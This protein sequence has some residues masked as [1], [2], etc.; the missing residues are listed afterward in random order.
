MKYSKKYLKLSV[1]LAGLLVSAQA[2]ALVID[3]NTYL[4][5]NPVTDDATVAT[6]TLTQN[7]S[8]VDFTFVNSVN[9][10]AGNIGDDAFISLLLFSYDGNPV[11]T[12]SSFG[13]FGGTQTVTSG[14]FGINPPGSDAGYNFFLD[15]DYPT[16]SSSDRFTDGENT[17]WTVFGVTVTDFSVTVPGSGPDSLAMVHIQQV[18]AGPG[19]VGSL[20]FV[21]NGGGPPSQELPE[22]GTL[23]LLGLG[24]LGFGASR[25]YQKKK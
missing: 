4:T 22:P 20:K 21:G 14:D 7:G 18:G 8:N 1:A 5:G 3:I 15:L 25:R 6:L 24:L 19:G 13:N 17:T 10:L 23:A 11:L 2:S 12:S 9:N 16:A